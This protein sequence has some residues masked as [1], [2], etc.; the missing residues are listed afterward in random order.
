[1][2]IAVIAEDEI[3]KELQGKLKAV[4]ELE[5]VRAKTLKDLLSADDADA[6]FDLEFQMDQDR[7]K[8]L[9]SLLPR[10]VFINAVINTLEEIGQP[11]IRINAW[12]TFMG[13]NICELAIDNDSTA[14]ATK[15]IMNALS[16]QYQLVPDKPGMISARIIA[17]IINEAYFATQEQVSSKGDID[18][19]M[20]LGTNY[21]HGPFDWA[22]Q[23][24]LKNILQLLRALQKTDDRYS[25]STMLEKE[26]MLAK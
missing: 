15:K 12:P 9:V 26:T 18:I 24:G 7:I 19:A 11:F 25:I 8:K 2:K 4:E 20:K 23:I 6:F 22:T 3:L 1:M 17:M 14:E 13:R 21:P 10:P 16:W 5:L